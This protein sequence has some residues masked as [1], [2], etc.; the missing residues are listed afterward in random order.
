[1]VILDVFLK[2]ISNG[3]TGFWDSDMLKPGTNLK[4]LV[5]LGMGIKTP[6]SEAI[7]RASLQL[8]FNVEVLR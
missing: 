7:F 8:Y 6:F 3:T 5:E 2:T 4:E 1:L